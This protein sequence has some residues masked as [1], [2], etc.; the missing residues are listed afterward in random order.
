MHSTLWLINSYLHCTG[1]RRYLVRT[2]ELS[3]RL[4]MLLLSC[5]SKTLSLKVIIIIISTCIIIPL[6]TVLFWGYID[7]SC[8]FDFRDSLFLFNFSYLVLTFPDWLQLHSVLLYTLIAHV[9]LQIS[10]VLVDFIYT[11]CLC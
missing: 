4:L 7:T 8:L 2:V 1:H 10:I 6:N 5:K 11:H 3:Y 9:W